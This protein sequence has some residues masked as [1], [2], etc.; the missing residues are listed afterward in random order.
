MNRTFDLGPSFSHFASGEYK[1]VLS[2]TDGK[3]NWYGNITS[4]VT[5]S[6]KYKESFG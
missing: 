6:T 1:S 2:W 3:D 5:V 4:L